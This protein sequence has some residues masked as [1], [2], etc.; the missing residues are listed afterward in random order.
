MGISVTENKTVLPDTPET[1]PALAGADLVKE[2][3]AAAWEKKAIH[4][5]AMDVGE[6]VGYTDY[7]VIC[8]GNSDRQVNAIAEHIEA[9]LKAN[10]KIRPN[11]IEGRSSGRWILLDYVDVVIHILYQPVRDYYEL[12]KLWSD[13]KQ[14][15]LEEPEW[16][17]ADPAS[18]WDLR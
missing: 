6:L 9:T 4:L 10:H 12:E 18:P 17:Q 1:P 11:G 13:A 15:E 5:V 3:A 14:I 7:V 16:L 2:I 8:S